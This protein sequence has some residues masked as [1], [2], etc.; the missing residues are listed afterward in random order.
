MN[1]AEC[2]FERCM[3]FYA[4][5]N[6]VA[7]WCATGREEQLWSKFEARCEKQGAT[8]AVTSIQIVRSAKRRKFTIES[9]MFMPF[10]CAT[11]T[12][13]NTG[14]PHEMKHGTMLPVYS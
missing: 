8:A 3:A 7:G 4:A 12:L 2:P 11:V 1:S 14:I 10:Y 5:Q 13:F 9:F 6:T